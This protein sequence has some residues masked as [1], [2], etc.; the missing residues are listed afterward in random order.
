M[1]HLT[2]QH[3]ALPHGDVQVTCW[4]GD[5]GWFCRWRPELGQ[6]GS[7]LLPLPLSVFLL[8]VCVFLLSLFP[9]TSSKLPLSPGQGVH[10]TIYSKL[11]CLSV[12]LRCTSVINQNMVSYITKLKK[13]KGKK[14]VS[15]VN[16]MNQPLLL[17][18]HEPIIWLC[19]CRDKKLSF[20]RPRCSVYQRN[21]L[22]ASTGCPIQQQPRTQPRLL[23]TRDIS[24]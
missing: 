1:R 12:C 23:C 8:S 22:S 3:D 17:V 16:R 21:P 11:L 4:T 5:R 9:W 24:I 10:Q 20:F 6:C 7:P 19:L 14:Q 13:K 15:R 2:G 18:R